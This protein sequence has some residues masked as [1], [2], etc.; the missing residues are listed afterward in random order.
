MA[1]VNLDKIRKGV[2]LVV[3]REL[4]RKWLGESLPLPFETDLSPTAFM[5]RLKKRDRRLKEV[6]EQDPELE[7]RVYET[8]SH[9]VKDARS[10]F[11]ARKQAL[12]EFA[13]EA[14]KMWKDEG[15]DE[16]LMKAFVKSKLI[17]FWRFN[18]DNPFKADRKFLAELKQAKE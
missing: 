17:D 10:E 5:Q 2:M 6:L 13:E 8:I 15:W 16:N 18:R 14:R 1:S 11:S 9:A 12:I 3:K 7:R 4:L